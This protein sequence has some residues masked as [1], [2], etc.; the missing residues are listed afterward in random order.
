M[1]KFIIFTQ[2]TMASIVAT[3]EILNKHHDQI[4]A[5]VLASQLKGESF[6]DQVKVAYKL[7]KKSSVGFFFYKLI[8]SKLYNGLLSGHRLLKTKKYQQGEAVT[9]EDLTKKFH[10]QVI[11]TNNLSDEQFLQ[12]IKAMNPDYIFCL[13]AQILKK[14]VF[15]TLGNK[16]INAHGSYLPQYRGAA[17]YFWYLINQDKQFGVTVHFMEA[18]LDTGNIIFQKKFDYD[19]HLSVYQLHYQLSQ[20]FGLMLNEFIEDYA[21]LAEVP[22]IKQDEEKVTATR[23]PTKEDIKILRRRRNKLVPWKDFL[24][25]I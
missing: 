14:N 19:S 4:S 24:Q 15:E 21:G 1:A 13:V 22:S 11:R 23:M 20:H 25:N 17:Q 10:I 2:N 12:Q 16:L 6:L 18:G 7:I 3:R 8:E 9:I 5:V